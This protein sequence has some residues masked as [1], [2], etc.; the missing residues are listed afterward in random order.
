MTA[1]FVTIIRYGFSFLI[2]I[3]LIAHFSGIFFT[4][5]IKRS[6]WE[7]VILS[8][9]ILTLQ[10]F[11]VKFGGL[12]ITFALYPIH[13]HIPIVL[14]LAIYCKVSWRRSVFSLFIGYMLLQIPNWFSQLINLSFDEYGLFKLLIYLLTGALLIFLVC[15]SFTADIQDMINQSSLSLLVSIILPAIYYLF[16]YIT[17]VWSDLLYS[18]NWVILQLMPTVV[19]VSFIIYL[20]F[21]SREQMN[22]EAAQREK[23]EIENRLAMTAAEINSLDQMQEQTKVYRHDMRHHFSLLLSMAEEGLT[24][25]IKT[26]LKENIKDI[27]SF[28]PPR[29]YTDNNM[30]NLILSRLAEIAEAN[31]VDYSFDIRILEVPELSVTELCAMVSN[32]IENAL[33]AVCLLPPTE[34]SVK[35]KLSEFNNNLVF[36]VKNPY[37]GV[38]RFKDGLPFNPEAEHGLGTKSIAAIVNSHKGKVVFDACKQIFKLMIIIPIERGKNT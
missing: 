27:A 38:V 21:I 13:T 16:D 29:K 32:A 7:L 36:V 19:C 6:F 14:F 20:Y 10:G 3:V 9:I 33:N 22:H 17:G 5:P 23:T 26:Y 25:D 34:R 15:R 12:K 2:A 35:V 24:E 8:V 18:H 4:R 1:D 11:I 30:L 31:R 37:K 28:A